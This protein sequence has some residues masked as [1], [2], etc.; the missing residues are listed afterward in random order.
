MPEKTETHSRPSIDRGEMSVDDHLFIA[1][2]MHAD[3]AQRLVDEEVNLNE[4]LADGHLDA[5][6]MREGELNAQFFAIWVEPQFYGTGGQR[7]IERADSQIAAVHRLARDNPET[8]E[9][10][11][12]AADI[13][14]IANEGKLA[15]LIGLEGAYAIDER[16][17]MVER[18][19]RMG[20]RYMSPTW[21][22]STIWAGSSGDQVG[23]TRGLDDF[24]KQVIREMN[25]LGMMI[26]VS[27]VSDRTFW[28]IIDTST[29][30][31]IA[32]HSGARSIANVSRNLDDEQ[33]RAIANTGGVCSV[34]FYPAFLEP[35]WREKKNLVEIEIARL[36][37]E[38]ERHTEGSPSQKRM[39]CDRVREREFARRLPP[40]PVARV[41]DH[42]DHIVR[43]TSVDHVGIG[44]DFDGIQATPQGL[45]SVAELPNLAAELKRS[46]YSET[47]VG[48]IL[49]GNVLRVMED[50]AQDDAGVEAALK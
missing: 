43:L 7:A 5:V 50:V 30:P 46:G 27:H 23:R 40:V 16:L 2:D 32:T 1:V 17:E 15:A 4:R 18:Y 6:R 13:R 49:G 3:T 22:V 19:F 47:D 39:A 21:T 41:V 8:W 33:L 48:K 45:S 28:D 34:V 9:L 14:R 20:V 12:T 31:V 10:A 37:R 11:T 26:D 44:S 42:I 38:A 29:K 25:R 36:V 24:G 35:G